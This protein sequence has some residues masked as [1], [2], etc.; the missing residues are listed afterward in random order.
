M[1]GAF[2]GGRSK[3]FLQMCEQ[4]SKNTHEDLENN[5]IAL[6]HDESHLNKYIINRRYKTLPCNY[7][8]PEGWNI[9][10]YKDDIKILLRDKA[11]KKYGGHEYLRS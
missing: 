4:L 6:W 3:E 2:N 8:Y 7:S 5:V 10:E 1:Q 11:N 9:E